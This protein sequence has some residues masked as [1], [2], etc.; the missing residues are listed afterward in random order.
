M[1]D[2][3]IQTAIEG[4]HE[5]KNSAYLYQHLAKTEHGT[6]LEAL[7]LNL[8]QAAEKQA[9]LWLKTLPPTEAHKLTY[10]TDFRTKIVVGLISTLGPKA[11]KPVLASM[12]IRGLSAYLGHIPGHAPIQTSFDLTKERQHKA[13]GSGNNLRAAVFGINDGLISNACLILGIAGS[14][15]NINIIILSGVAGLTAGA[16]S[17]AAG[18][19]ISVRSQRE[20]F[21]YQIGLE[22]AEL[23][24]YPEEEAAELSFIYQSRGL[25]K[26][27]ADALSIKMLENKEHALDTLAREELGLNPDELGS[28]PKAALASFMAFAIGGAIPLVPFLS[29]LG[30][31]ALTMSISLTAIALFGVGA[32]LSLFTGR[33]AF[34]SGLRMLLIGMSAGLATNFIGQLVGQFG[35]TIN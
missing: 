6:P 24:Q 28:P 1:N 27:D 12:K 35:G 16:M 19:Y 30:N 25:S 32:T 21:E 3:K 29:S 31:Y 34:Y 4:W 11:I 13:I 23:I 20:L 7:F 14:T 15:T 10:K 5:E 8:A 26:P 17:M 33:N 18:E 9:E 22:R 2:N